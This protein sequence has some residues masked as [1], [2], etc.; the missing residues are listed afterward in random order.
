MAITILPAIISILDLWFGA[1]LRRL[2]ERARVLV[3]LIA[4]YILD[5]ILVPLIT[6]M[7]DR[8]IFEVMGYSLGC[9]LITEASWMDNTQ[10]MSLMICLTGMVII[11]GMVVYSSELHSRKI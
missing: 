5:K 6:F 9:Q 1:A 2:Y 10:S 11:K 8:G 3:M 7:H 4:E